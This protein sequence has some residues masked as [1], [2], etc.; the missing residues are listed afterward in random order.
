MRFWRPDVRFDSWKPGRNAND[1]PISIVSFH[2]TSE[3]PCFYHVSHNS[4]IWKVA[5]NTG[6]VSDPAGCF[7]LFLTSSSIL[8]SGY[9]TQSLEALS[10]TRQRCHT[11]WRGVP[12]R[13]SRR[14]S[15]SRLGLGSSKTS[16][17]ALLADVVPGWKSIR[18]LFFSEVDTVMSWKK[19][20]H[21]QDPEES[22]VLSAVS[23]WIT[24]IIS[25]I[26][27]ISV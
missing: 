21:W 10:S 1:K 27:N 16:M 3:I 9:I 22:S 12:R 11:L 20:R 6:T 2:P 5:M 18:P 4:F 19:D 23:Y 7:C 14:G 25:N 26:S 8:W 24:V 17:E 13:L 15:A